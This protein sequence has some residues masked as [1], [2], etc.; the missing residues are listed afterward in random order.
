M[1]SI[2]IAVFSI[3]ALAGA[4]AL[5]AGPSPAR[6][7]VPARPPADAWNRLEPGLELGT[8][9][10]G[11]S[12]GDS[13]ATVHVLRIDPA[14]FSLTLLNASAPAEGTTHS[15][16]DWCNRHGLVACVNASM[17]RDDEKTS[18]GLMKT[19]RHVNNPKV[20]GDN[21]LLVFDGPGGPRILDRACD[22]G[23]EAAAK[24]GTVVQ[25]IRMLDC[26]GGNVWA[27]QP[28][29][30]STAAI[31]QDSDGRI[32][33]IHARDPLPVHDLVDGL[34]GLPLHLTRL[35]YVE[36]GPEAQLYV[37]AGGEEHEFLGSFETGFWEN[38]DNHDGWPVPNVIGVARVAGT[39]GRESGAGEP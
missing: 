1:S 16:K 18:V 11:E 8:F 17:Y 28:R 10:V 7:P 34:R 35:L 20:N 33:F 32:L 31:G 12:H 22:G 36:G 30:W 24:Y 4:V 37:A 3:L 9:V 5:A 29:R 38:D 6:F 14:K 21:A 39:N 27:P 13:T 19:R 2:R 15:M 25:D 26:E 23:D